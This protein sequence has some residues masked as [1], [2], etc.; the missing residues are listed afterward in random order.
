MP[1][2]I[3]TKTHQM[4]T[5][6]DLRNLHNLDPSSLRTVSR[7]QL[8]KPLH[9]LEFVFNYAHLPADHPLRISETLE[10]LAWKN[11]DISTQAEKIGW[12]SDKSKLPVFSNEDIYL[13]FNIHREQSPEFMQTVC[14]HIKSL[15]PESNDYT[16]GTVKA[17]KAKVL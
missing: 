2:V 17:K 14:P 7:V 13:P 3:K 4:R 11:S 8:D 10:W 6:Y 16:S 15:A 12:V 1:I 5:K 9:K